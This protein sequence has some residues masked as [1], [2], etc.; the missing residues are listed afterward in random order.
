MGDAS[1]H[2]YRVEVSAGRVEIAA[3]ASV[4]VQGAGGAQGGASVQAGGRAWTLGGGEVRVS[5]VADLG[6]ALRERD[7]RAGR[8]PAARAV[9]AADRGA[10]RA[11]A[12]GAGGQPRVASPERGGAAGARAHA[13]RVA[14]AVHHGAHGPLDRRGARRVVLDERPRP[15]GDALHVRPAR[16]RD[17]ARRRARRAREVPRGPPAGRHGQRRRVQLGAAHALGRAAHD[18]R[19]R[20]ERGDPLGRGPACGG[21]DAPRRGAPGRRG[22][23]RRPGRDGD[24]RAP[25]YRDTERALVLF[26][27]TLPARHIRLDVVGVGADQD[28]PFLTQLATTGGGTARNN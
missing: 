23:V 27:G 4:G 28:V 11:R 26:A 20:A 13:R 25:T 10:R 24:R 2:R 19:Q 16:V 7:D 9:R 18:R 6:G 17:E 8:G 5:V 15:R 21:R 22:H 1:G 12:L 14:G 3:Q